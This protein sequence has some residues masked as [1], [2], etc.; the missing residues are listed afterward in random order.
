MYIY[1][2]R[3]QMDPMWIDARSESDIIIP[4]LQELDLT[5]YSGKHGFSLDRTLSCGQV[6]VW[7]KMGRIWLG[8]IDGC[9]VFLSQQGSNLFY[10]GIS[11]DRLIAYLGLDHPI[12]EIL[13]DISLSIKEYTAC[14]IQTIDDISA[15]FYSDIS[16]A[17][18]L[19]IV[20]Q[21]PWECIAH[22]ILS[23]NSNIPTIRKRIRLLSE[24]YGI[25]VGNNGSYTF[26]GFDILASADISDIMT[27]KTGYRG[28][29]LL[30]T[31][32]FIRENPSF[33]TKIDTLP[34]PDAKCEL[35]TLSGVGP[36]VADCVLLFAYQRYEAVPIDVWIK[37][38]II[39]RYFSHIADEEQK[40]ISYED[41]SVF[42]R[43]YFGKHA[44]YA[45]QF[46]YAARE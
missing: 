14:N 30:K 39:R 29:Y 44:G 18:G 2:A 7:T 21:D 5:L 3:D 43:L 27:C 45:Q 34:Y 23:T 37:N 13:S 9:E 41:I 15:S 8:I 38:I 11:S 26:P 28:P 35:M 20:R 17:A 42:C 22:F 12:D 10:A 33:L 24:K 36:K 19:R 1:E 16:K 25:S 46:I 31:G 40:K 4:P 32:K 6:F